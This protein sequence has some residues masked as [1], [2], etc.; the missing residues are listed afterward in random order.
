M[1]ADMNADPIPDILERSGYRNSRNRLHQAGSAVTV[2][3]EEIDVARILLPPF[4]DQCQSRGI[5]PDM[6][7]FPRFAFC[8]CVQMIV[9]VEVGESYRQQIG[10][11]KREVDADPPDIGVQVTVMGSEK[12]L[13]HH[14]FFLCLDRFD[15][16]HVCNTI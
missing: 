5:Q 6:P 4:F 10:D 3:L 7:D 1:G 15:F 14:N 2:H 12:S 13:D 9:Q 8:Q 11:S 16:F